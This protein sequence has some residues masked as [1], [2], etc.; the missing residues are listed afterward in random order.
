M[1]W[2]CSIGYYFPNLSNTIVQRNNNRIINLLTTEK[3]YFHTMD[4]FGHKC[5]GFKE[6]G[7]VNGKWKLFADN[8]W[9][10]AARVEIVKIIR[11]KYK[12]SA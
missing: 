11:C 8:D 1:S 3:H 12:Q 2:K 6:V 4:N 7:L 9:F 10:P 5:A